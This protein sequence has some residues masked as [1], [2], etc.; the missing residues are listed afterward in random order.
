MEG[1]KFEPV[2]LEPGDMFFLIH[3]SP[4]GLVPI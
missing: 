2:L 1:M 3:L 4:T